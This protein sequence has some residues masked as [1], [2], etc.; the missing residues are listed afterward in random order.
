MTTMVEAIT[1]EEFIGYL[2]AMARNEPWGEPA[3]SLAEAPSVPPR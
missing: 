3:T 1:D 2:A